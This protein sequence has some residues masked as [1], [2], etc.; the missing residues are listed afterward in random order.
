MPTNPQN[1]RLVFFADIV[2]QI[3][4]TKLLNQF[5][6]RRNRK[7]KKAKKFTERALNHK[8]VVTQWFV[9]CQPFSYNRNG[10]FP[11]ENTNVRASPD[12]VC[13]PF[14]RNRPAG[15]TARI[16]LHNFS[17][18]FTNGPGIEFSISRQML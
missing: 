14:R 6:H 15:S 5:G 18:I 9:F 12:P 3:R 11:L 16:A 1:P 2:R 8:K 7:T 10:R 4:A 17:L 13:H